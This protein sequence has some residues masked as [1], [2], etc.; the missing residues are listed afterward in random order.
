MNYWLKEHWFYLKA[1]LGL[2]PFRPF[3]PKLYIGKT[4]VGVPLFLPRKW[5]PSKEKEGYMT[6]IPLKFGFSSCT[7]GWKTKW[8]ETDYRHEWNPVW[9][10]VFFG[11]QI[12]LIFRPDNDMHYWECY[13]TYQYATDKSKTVKARIE[14]ARVINP[15]VWISGVKENEAKTC[16]W[17]L[18]LKDKWLKR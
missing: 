6:P 11:Y 2:S 17:D 10:F 3:L 14:Q 5:V 4:S 16:Y 13:L 15:C 8:R 18:I 12:A 1:S 9:S 7:L